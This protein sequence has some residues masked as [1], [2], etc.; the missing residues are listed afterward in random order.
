VT[1]N[2]FVPCVLVCD[3]RERWIRTVNHNLILAPLRS[4]TPMPSDPQLLREKTHD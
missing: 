4:T 2:E 3:G 1:S